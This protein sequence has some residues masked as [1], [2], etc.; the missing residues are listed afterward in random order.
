MSLTY[1][2]EIDGIRTVAIISVLIYHAKFSIL[3]TEILSGGF[4][5]VDVFFVLSGFLITSL[6]HKEWAETGEFSIIHFY[7]RRARRLL[8]ALF[9]VIFV[10]WLLAW[11]TL[12][13]QQMI[14][15]V[16]SQISS[17]FFMS[18]L[19]WWDASQVY[20][21]RSGLF[22]PFLHTWSLAVEEQF[23]IL[24]PFI[25]L[26]LI[27]TF[28]RD[29]FIISIGFISI[30]VGI[31]FAEYVNQQSWSLSFFWLPSRFWEL[32]SGALLAFLLIRYPTFGR[33]KILLQIMPLIG[34]T[35]IVLSM[36]VMELQLHHP[37][38]GT[39]ATILGTVLLIWFANPNE[40]TTRILSSKIFVAIGLISYSLYL[41]HYPIFSIARIAGYDSGHHKIAWIILS[42][43]AAYLTYLFVETPFR[44]RDTITARK[45]IYCLFGALLVIATFTTTIL[46]NDGLKSRLSHLIEVYGVNEFDNEILR[47]ESWAVLGNLASKQGHERSTAYEPSKFEATVEWFS[48]DPTTEKLLIIGNSHAKDMFNVLHLSQHLFPGKEFARF[49]LDANLKDNQIEQLFASPNFK[50]ASK[51][52]ISFKYQQETFPPLEKLI[53]RIKE[54]GK[55]VVLLSNT[56]EFNKINNLPIFDWNLR[57][58]NAALNRQDVNELAWKNRKIA[59]VEKM[60][61]KLRDLS[62]SLGVPI[63]YKE[64]FICDPQQKSCDLITTEGIKTLYDYGHY[65][66][67]GAKYFGRKIAAA[68]WLEGH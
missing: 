12:L 1:R 27:K 55:A 46:L 42:F 14:D 68:K 41:W 16:Q 43:L 4:L 13:P 3:G 25:Y 48:S 44:Q 31:L 7:E 9:V 18:N 60:N 22:E 37:G 49:G 33:T 64:K 56:P 47:Q 28:K 40:I 54:Q 57:R 23:Y 2:P 58:N 63:L 29:R 50:K 32:L 5:G 26:F 61:N 66:T 62:M 67:A 6:I 36:W 39:F 8:P 45:L 65:T 10:S 19:Y 15:L 51:T 30:A 52:L 11:K 24:F 53:H 34:M 17:I 20:G 35:L 21:A 38:S 59:A